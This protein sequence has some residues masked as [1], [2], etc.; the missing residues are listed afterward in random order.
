MKKAI[1]PGSFDPFTL[2]H[3]D[4]VNRGLKLFDHIT[5]GIGRN[6]IKK[7]T[8]P[9]RERL[10]AI[11]KIYQDNPKVDVQIYDCLTVDFAKEVGAKFILRGIRCMQDFEYERNMAEANK[12]LSDMETILLYTRPEYAHISSTLVRDL[13]AYHKDVSAFVPNK[14]K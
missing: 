12:Q 4:I 9:I 14:L 1:F 5:I 2:G 10:A 6:S 8:F 11:Q 13:Y 3:Y 7:E